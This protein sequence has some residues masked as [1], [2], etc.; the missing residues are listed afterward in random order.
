MWIALLV[1]AAVCAFGL[2]STLSN[3]R[4]SR[5]EKLEHD[6]RLEAEKAQRDASRALEPIVVS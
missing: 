4:C 6:L 2:L 1:A 3:E 5:V